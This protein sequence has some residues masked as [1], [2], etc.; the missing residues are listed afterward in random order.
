[1]ESEF[2]LAVVGLRINSEHEDECCV[3]IDLISDS[4]KSLRSEIEES[5]IAKRDQIKSDQVE[6][7]IKAG[8]FKPRRQRVTTKQCTRRKTRLSRE[9]RREVT[10]QIQDRKRKM[11]H[12]AAQRLK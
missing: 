11:K 9:L 10:K 4:A 7:S 8:T 5:V 12:Q 2:E 3:T 1:M 6:A